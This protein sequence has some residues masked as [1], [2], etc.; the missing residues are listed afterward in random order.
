MNT[1][2]YIIFF[3]VFTSSC[4]V[5]KEEI[6]TIPFEYIKN[7]II[8]ET[9]LNGNNK[10]LYMLLDTGVD[11]SVIDLTTAEEIGLKINKNNEGNASGRGNEK[12]SVY[13]TEMNA[14]LIEGRNYGDIEGLAFNLKGIEKKLGREIHGI[15]GYSFLKDKIFRIDYGE[16]VIQFFKSKEQLL[17]S[18][19]GKSKKLDFITEGEDMIPLI[20]D[21]TINDKPFIA[22]LDTGSSL[23]LQVYEHRLVDIRLD[24][25]DL[26]KLKKS[27]LYGAQG[28]KKTR[29]TTLNSIALDKDV[30]LN[31]QVLTISTIKNTD[32]LR[33]GNI[34]NKFLKN[35]RV[36]F[37]YINQEITF[38]YDKK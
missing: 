3:I 9:T 31:N 7:Q 18:I 34:G 38:E 10:K 5:Q 4:T 1:A 2:T 8:L 28:N 32:Q 29:K 23:N 33:M 15:L 16:K 24:T 12:V 21:L 27:Q 25:L 19:K 35:F 37:D 6:K 22:S 30:I 11:P 13:P 17:S 36:S 20:E 14:L 26:E